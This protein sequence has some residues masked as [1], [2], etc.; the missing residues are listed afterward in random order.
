[1]GTDI[2]PTAIIQKGAELDEGVTVGPFSIINSAVRLGRNVSVASNVIIEGDT[3]IGENT[4]VHPFACLGLAPQDVKYSGE[5]TGLR[6]GRGNVIREFATIHR[7]SVGG[8]GFT[9]VGDNCFLM[10]YSHVAHDCR[11]GNNVI[12]AN[13]ATLG[14][15]VTVQ[16]YAVI[17]GLSAIHQF[18]RIGTHAMVGGFSAI[19][20]DVPPYTIVSGPRAKLYGLN[21][22]GLKRHG[23]TDDVINELK[24]A[25][26]IIF[27]GEKRNLKEALRKVQEELPYT[28]EI[29]TLVEFINANKRGICR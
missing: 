9:E 29:S 21:S 19:V 20:Q 14:G 4:A 18:T 26:M 15:H 16:D 28:E 10:A 5:K 7:A 2:H 24:K 11:V 12:M 27:R 22:I 17:G 3:E 13:A 6:I 23:L 25:Y 8:E 1:M